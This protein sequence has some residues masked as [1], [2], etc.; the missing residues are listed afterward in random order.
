MAVAVK[1]PRIPS[2]SGDARIRV[3]FYVYC[4]RGSAV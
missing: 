4:Q 3:L 2:I 1:V